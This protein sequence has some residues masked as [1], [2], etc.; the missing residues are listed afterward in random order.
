MFLTSHAVA[1]AATASL[2]PQNPFLAFIA[3]FLSHFALDAIPHW[4]YKIKSSSVNPLIG[5]KMRYDKNFWEDVIH[6][7]S[8]GLI[9]IFLALILFTSPQNFWVIL[10]GIFGGILPDPLQFLY[11]QFRHEPLIS[12]FKF[13]LWVHTKRDTEKYPLLY[14]SLEAFV[15]ILIMIIA[16]Y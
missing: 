12:L 6:I 5:A 11:I 2:F 10:W 8:D 3:G 7:G 9:G 1:G 4:D 13:H 15:I 14:F 16:K